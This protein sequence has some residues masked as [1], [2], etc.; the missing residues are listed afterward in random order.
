MVLSCGITGRVKGNGNK[1]SHSKRKT[2]RKYLLNLQK[3]SLFSQTLGRC[4]RFRIA[5]RT[6]R[7]IDFKGGFDAYIMRTP[8]QKLTVVARRIKSL[9]LSKQVSGE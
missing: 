3:V 6:L 5:T 4:V 8:S 2:K 7:T 1:V 9:L